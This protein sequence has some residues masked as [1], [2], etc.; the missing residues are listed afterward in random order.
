MTARKDILE[1]TAID[2][3]SIPPLVFRQIRRKLIKTT[4]AGLDAGITLHHVEIIRL[5]EKEGE[6]HV[7]EIGDRLQIARAQMTALVD[8]LV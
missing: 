5:L 2:L 3:L 4:L 8:K 1:Q 6:L 7:A